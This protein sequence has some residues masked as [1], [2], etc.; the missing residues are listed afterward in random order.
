MKLFKLLFA[1]L[2]IASNLLAQTNVFP[3]NGNTGIGTLSPQVPL[4]I[5]A[6]GV[7]SKP[8]GVVA[9]TL[10][11]LRFAR[12]GTPYYS[13]NEAADFRIGHGGPSGSGSKLD[14]FLNG[15]ANTTS[16]PDQHV[17]T[18]LYNGNVGV[19]TPTPISKLHILVNGADINMGDINLSAN[20]LIIEAHTGGRSTTS[21]AQIEFAIPANG[22]GSNIWSQ[23]RI[24][25]VAGSTTV[26]DASG[27]MI[28]GT[29]RYFNKLGMG[30]QWFYGDD[31]VIDAIGNIGVGTLIPNEKLA[32][33]GKIRAKEIKVEPNPATWPDYVFEKNYKVGTLEELELFIKANKHLPE[34]PTAKEVAANGVELGEMNKLLLKKVE[35]LTLHLI[36]KDKQLQDSNKRLTYLEEESKTMKE[37]LKIIQLK[38]SKP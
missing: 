17:M 28:L 14:L 30:L 32:V 1:M 16:I 3:A 10:T 4:E 2:F 21:G 37:L 13:Y 36:E 7:T 22:D 18:W 34:M 5:W 9:P 29:R 19:G 25:T 33:N 26:G 31:L 35:E 24:V 27:K 23:G 20:A 6:S 12:F 8:D 38:L 11:A 15:V